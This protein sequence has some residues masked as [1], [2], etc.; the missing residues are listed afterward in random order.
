MEIVATFEPLEIPF[1]K[2]LP[3]IK[4]I[5]LTN[6]TICKLRNN[7]YK[8]TNSVARYITIECNITNGRYHEY[9]QSYQLGIKQKQTGGNKITTIGYRPWPRCN[10][11]RYD[12]VTVIDQCLCKPPCLI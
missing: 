10:A 1:N 8:Q 5:K 6:I 2:F 9:I 11:N 3:H 4:Y 12:L 7:S